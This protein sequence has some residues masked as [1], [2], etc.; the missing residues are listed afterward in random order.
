M[1]PPKLIKPYVISFARQ[2]V[3]A[4]AVDLFYVP[5]RPISG[6]SLNDCFAVVAAHIASNGGKAVLGWA[7]WERPNVY[8]EAE[9]HTVWQA[10]SGEYV[11]ISPRPVQIPRILFLRDPARTY[12]GVQVDNIRKPFCTDK[13]VKRFL[14]LASVRFRLFNEGELRNYHGPVSTTPEML[15]NAKEIFILEQKIA[16]RYG[17]WLPESIQHST[18]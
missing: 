9:L 3:R 16:T 10:P 12:R 14:E 2:I 11:D 15:A 8:I 17:N 13:N 6:A 7:L 5:H 1:R 18:L 4:D